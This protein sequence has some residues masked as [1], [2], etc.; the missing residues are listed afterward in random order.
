MP[1]ASGKPESPYHIPVIGEEKAGNY[2]TGR[3]VTYKSSSTNFNDGKYGSDDGGKYGR[4]DDNKY[5]GYDSGKYGERFGGYDGG[6][7]G[8]DDTDGFAPIGD[9]GDDHGGFNDDGFGPSP[10]KYHHDVSSGVGM[11]GDT[12]GPDDQVRAI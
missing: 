9:F 4:Y 1:M 2:G 11:K 10:F 6:S 12:Y 3:G 5:G 7:Y 8:L